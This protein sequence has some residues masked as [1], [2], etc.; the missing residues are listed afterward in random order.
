MSVPFL[1]GRPLDT[2]TVG[3]DNNYNLVRFV[4]ALMVL[5]SHSFALCLGPG[6]AEPL[7][8]LVGMTLGNVAVDVFFFTS[9]FLVTGSLIKR[10]GVGAF[11]AARA[12]RVM[13]GLIACVV[14]CVLGIGL[15]F[16]TLP[17]SEF[18]A[19]AA[20]RQYFLKNVLLLAGAAFELPGVFSSLPHANVV[21]GSLWTLP[22]EVRLYL[23]LAGIGFGARSLSM[24]AR[25]IRLEVVVSLLAAALVAANVTNH[26]VHFAA[27]EALQVGSMFFVGAAVYA[28]RKRI[29]ISTPLVLGAGLLLVVC[30]SQ[31]NAFFVAYQLLLP[32]IV[33]GLAYLPG[34]KI[35]LFNRVGDYSYGLYLYAFP[36]QQAVVAT[37]GIKTPW[38]MGTISFAITLVI[39]LGSWHFLESRWLRRSRIQEP[40]GLLP[41]RKGVA[42][43]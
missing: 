18:L 32:L 27:R 3:R 6:G 29:L 23:I 30:G 39:A 1:I 31:R 11:L 38:L 10:G 20:T 15:L 24:V 40:Q 14:F 35:R 25:W 22:Q 7:E 28:N 2:F 4:A 9:G 8:Q 16:T 5:V 36:I 21:N 34:G 42:H 37:T 12:R 13:P 43:E 33:L 26:F 41:G 19:A 17:S